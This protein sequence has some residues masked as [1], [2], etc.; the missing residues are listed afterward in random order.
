[1]N[2][3]MSKPL[4]Y[5]ISKI[6][7]ISSAIHTSYKLFVWARCCHSAPQILL[8]KIANS[9]FQI[10]SS[11]CCPA[12][13]ASLSLGNRRHSNPSQRF[14]NS[15]GIISADAGERKAAGTWMRYPSA[16]SQRLA[17]QWLLDACLF[18]S[19]LSLNYH[20]HFTITKLLLFAT[21]ARSASRKNAPNSK[22][23]PSWIYIFAKLWIVTATNV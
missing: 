11:C 5:S 7:S 3:D 20:L 9:P 23:L 16:I 6:F 4:N 13:M 22:T 19:E 12:S 15:H 18:D 17:S 14:I 2:S 1:M 21:D 10:S 8:R